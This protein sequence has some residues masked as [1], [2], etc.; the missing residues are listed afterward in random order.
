MKKIDKET[1]LARISVIIGKHFEN[2]GRELVEDVELAKEELIIEIE[3]IL[4]QTEISVKHLVIERLDAD[5]EI[6]EE[7]KHRWKADGTFK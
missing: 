4:K 1:A 3:G 2:V 6:K 5:N 7:L